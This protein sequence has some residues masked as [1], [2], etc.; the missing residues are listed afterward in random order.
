[1]SQKKQAIRKSFRDAVFKRDKYKCVICGKK[2]TSDT[3]EEILDSHH[4]SPRESMPEGGYVKENGVSL[5]K[6]NDGESCHE[7][8]EAYLKGE[9]V[10]LR[11]APDSLYFLIGS[12]KEKALKASEKLKN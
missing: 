6:G 12:S 3:A 10:D 4:I 2:A 9:N 8:A 7:K 1:M 5:C 11:F